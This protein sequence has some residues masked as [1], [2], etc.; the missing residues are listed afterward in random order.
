MVRRLYADTYDSSKYSD[1]NLLY[2]S[3]LLEP[4]DLSRT[5]VYLYGKDSDMFPLLNLTQGQGFSKSV[6]P[7]QL[8]DTQY[9][10][11]TFGR[12]KHV[13]PVVS[14]RNT[15][16]TKPGLNNQPFEVIMEDDW[17]IY[18]YGVT[19]PDQS[20]RC[21]IMKPAEQIGVN[22]YVYTFQLVGADATEYVSLDNFLPGRYWVMTVPTIPS[23]KSDGNAS[24]T[25]QPGKVTNQ[26]GFMRF[27]K[28]IA[29]NIS[30]KVTPIEF[31]TKGGGTT[32]M[33]M[34]FDMTLF[35]QDRMLL[36]EFDLWYSEY[37]RDE[38][39]RIMLK[40][41]KTGEPI[42]HGAGIFE[43][44]ESVGNTS[45][46]AAPSL[47][48]SKLEAVFNTI[49]ANRVDKTPMELVGYT[50]R[51][52]R[53]ALHNGM[54]ADAIANQYQVALGEKMIS[55][56]GGFLTYGAYFSQYR[57]IDGKTFSV[58]ETNLFDHGLYAEQ[59]RANGNLI[60]G[61]PAS[62][63]NIVFLDQ[64]RSETDGMRNVMHVAEK[65]REYITGIYKG[66]SPLP[67]VWG[68]IPESKIISTRRDISA[69]EVIQSQG[70]N[71]LNPTT[72][73]WLYAA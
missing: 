12:M 59:D 68:S 34:P 48:P 65:G 7:K 49:Y 4:V 2:K 41:E 37:N 70:I 3:R 39:G 67:A 50:G 23:S 14:L 64:S 11:N 47:S 15:S 26:F 1:E 45:S 17:F 40:D 28:E 18:Q 56:T 62:S 46:Y 9:T 20:H 30:N 36:T 10:W 21:R 63:Y 24:N 51:G 27:S 66:M 5:L 29:G 31:P 57:S 52:G 19:S 6:A 44:I 60:N 32:N 58:I 73:F 72:S 38:Y 16:N 54:L 33:W 42:P 35:E 43:Q 55:G 71:M 53:R 8:N 13:S 61:L 25:M 69:Y 22:Q